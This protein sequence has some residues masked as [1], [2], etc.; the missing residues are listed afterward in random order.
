MKT[1]FH[2]D[3]EQF[4]GEHSLSDQQLTMT[5]QYYDLHL[6][7]LE[8]F[9]RKF[10][11]IDYRQEN[12]DIS[13][14]REFIQEFLRRVAKL[15]KMGFVFV[16]SAPWE[17]I[18]SD[19]ADTPFYPRLDTIQPKH[20][21]WGDASWWWWY[22]YRKHNNKSFEFDHSD[23]KLDFL[24]LN[25]NRKPHRD[26]LWNELTKDDTLHN[27]LRT[28]LGL[29][30]NLK[31]P[32]EYELPWVDRENYPM[33]GMDQDLYEKPYND[34][35]ISIV[36]ETSDKKMFITEKIYKPLI[37]GHIFMVHG[38]NGIMAKLRELGFK[39]YQ[40]HIDE[41]YD[42]EVDD[43]LRMIKLAHSIREARKLDYKKLYDDTKYIREHNQQHVFDSKAMRSEINNTV[44][45]FFEFADGSQVSSTKS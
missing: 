36:S 45:L 1:G 15:K 10:A 34:T 2:V 4:L 7:D 32:A 22:M 17:Y 5:G 27:S 29:D 20:C 18:G 23:K 9:D 8:K 24:Y 37:A 14:N 21:W 33:R 3:I 11:L 19:T 12:K 16:Q 25:K 26:A 38:C 31:L 41:S 6:Y 28:N 39:T 40:D 44:N 42:Q 35:A 43:H 13:E 30:R